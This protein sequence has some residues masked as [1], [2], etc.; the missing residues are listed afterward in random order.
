MIGRGIRAWACRAA[1]AGAIAALAMLA[2]RD[3]GA[4]EAPTPPRIA[5][6]TAALLDAPQA[7]AIQQVLGAAALRDRAM[8]ELWRFYRERDYAPAWLD[9]DRPAPRARALL[10]SFDALEAQGLVLADYRVAE[11]RTLVEQLDQ[12]PVA[13]AQ[14][15]AAG[16]QAPAP[17]V[18]TERAAQFEIL[19][20]HA[21]LR[22]SRDLTGGRI[23]DQRLPVDQRPQLR[24][25]DGFGALTR[26][27][28]VEDAAAAFAEQAPRGEAYAG[29]VR[30]LAEYRRLV[31]AGG[32]PSVPE[33]RTLEPNTRDP[34]IVA[35]RRR[36]AVTD[37]A[38]MPAQNAERYDAELQAA[39]K[40][41]QRR[42]GFNEDARIGRA[43][44]A[45]MNVTAEARLRQVEAN[46]DR[47]RGLP[48]PGSDP[49]IFVNVP[50]FRLRVIQNGQELMTMAVIVGREAR[51]T[52][53][54][55]SRIV[56]IIINP[57]WTVPPKL[58][59]EDM[60]PHL[61]R[62]PDYLTSRNIRVY[63][64]GSM[65]EVNIA[66]VNW[67]AVQPEQMNSYLIRQEP[68]PRNAL[69]RLRF[70]LIN[71]PSIYLHDTPDRHYFQ[72]D[73]RSLSSGCIRVEQPMELALFILRNNPTPWT[74]ERIDQVIAGGERRSVPVT[75]SIPVH[76]VY[77]TAWLAADGTIAFR[78]DLYGF[79]DLIARGVETRSSRLSAARWAPRPV[80][81]AQIAR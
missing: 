1:A 3:A 58:A 25:I 19:F 2:A 7:Y 76:L 30:A 17:T 6:T 31:A 34:R 4:Q 52:P 20:S 10:A 8:R 32:W 29:L 64:R 81:G 55:S 73:Q 78:E 57:N 9:G 56:E 16:A 14:A 61:Q 23:A 18:A 65:Q 50:E 63:R 51:G 28:L 77:N 35:V 5:A 12:A 60:L 33:G 41:F 39:V 46:L 68:G 66:S 44:V 26:L 80:Q 15:P 74:Q 49:E 79:D 67:N 70:T 48:P 22:A 37:G 54:L 75:Q 53:P 59:R 27:S 47:M 62:D 36:L 71:T 72:R 69:G 42:H 11:L 40:R 38:A 13:G 24:P 43:T 45:A 21:V